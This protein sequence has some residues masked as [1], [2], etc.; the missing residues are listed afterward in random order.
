M[1]KLVNTAVILEM[2]KNPHTGFDQ[3]FQIPV[4]A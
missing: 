4:L 1:N 3:N 2:F